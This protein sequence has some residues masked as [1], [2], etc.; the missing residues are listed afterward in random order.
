MA[1]EGRLGLWAAFGK[2]RHTEYCSLVFY[3]PRGAASVGGSMSGERDQR[4]PVGV[5]EP[6]FA[7]TLAGGEVDTTAVGDRAGPICTASL[8]VRL[9]WG[10]GVEVEE[11]PRRSARDF[12]HIQRLSFMVE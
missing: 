2:E 4:L 10:A 3:Y 7:V 5:D 11:Q 12:C 8:L 9:V 1:S 6:H